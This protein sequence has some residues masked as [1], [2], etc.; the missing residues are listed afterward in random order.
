MKAYF[1]IIIFLLFA[2]SLSSQNIDSLENL[3]TSNLNKS[4]KINVLISLCEEYRT[5]DPNSMRLYAEELIT[6]SDGDSSTNSFAWAQY[7]LGDYYYIVDESNQTEKYFLS[8]YEIFK[9]RENAIGASKAAASLANIYFFFDRYK[10]SL[11]FAESA[12]DLAYQTNNKELQSNL[13][14]L[15]CDIYTYMEQYNLAIQHCVQALKIKE[16]LK[17]LKGKEVTMNSIGLIYQELGSY[18]KAEEYLFKALKLAEKN[19]QPY[20]IATTYSNIGNYFLVLGETEKALQNFQNAMQIDSVSQD[21]IGLAYSF[22]DIGK[23]YVINK[24]FD[25]ALS[26]LNKAQ[27]LATSQN[28]PELLA[29]IGIEKGEVFTS[30]SEYQKSVSVIKNSISIA[31]K[32]NSTPILKDCY[33]D[34]SKIYDEMG[35]KNNALIYMKLYMLESERKYKAENIKSIAEIEAI[36]K[37]DQKEQEI[38][39]LKKDNAIKELRAEQRTFFIAALG[40]GLVLLIILIIILYSRNK[41]KNR[42]NQALRE[43]NSAIQEQKEEIESQKEELAETSHK[44]SIQ[45][46]QITDSINYAKQIQ[47][48]LLPQVQTIKESFPESFIFYR[49]RDIVSGDFYWYTKIENKVAIA[50]VDCTGHGVPGAFMTVLAN[51]LLNQIVIETGITS[52]DLIVSLLDQKIQQN[53]HQENINSS[54]TDG[55]DIGLLMIDQ[56]KKTLE[57]TGTKIPLYLYQNSDITIIEPDRNSVGS[58]QLSEKDFTKKEIKYNEGDIIYLSSD[59]YQDQFGGSRNKKY[60]KSNFRI[61]LE[62]IAQKP[63]YEQESLI[64]KEF[65]NWRG[66][67]PQTDDILVIGLKL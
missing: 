65:I 42:T 30:R 64:E 44:L 49:A 25:E 32:I 53:L 15:M 35:D 37:I 63:I 26:Y 57:F 47:D 45:N 23:I 60:M 27:V 10:T 31:Q 43:Q 46:R 16:E 61:F 13:L 17:M 29:R 4:D 18:K 54:N 5:S 67:T 55:L 50:L 66:S 36:Y 8:A 41:I 2:H 14:S 9:N 58:T 33:Q 12:L 39:L 48:S 24:Q 3:L 28:M 22:F 19:A 38:D 11:S 59:G 52:P 1:P 51:S 62:K 20:N 21:K 34:L 7:Y 56:K 40:I 6:L